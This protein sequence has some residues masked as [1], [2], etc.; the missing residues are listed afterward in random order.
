M[1]C[2]ERRARAS[3][4]TSKSVSAG[5]AVVD[6]DDSGTLFISGLTI[7]HVRKIVTGILFVNRSLQKQ[8]IC[9]QSTF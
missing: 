6:A 8:I 9:T 5:C 2:I 1:T 7:S 3:W 4:Q